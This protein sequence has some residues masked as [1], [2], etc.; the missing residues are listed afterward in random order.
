MDLKT[1]V[2][3]K[4]VQSGLKK[5]PMVFSQSLD[6][7]PSQLMHTSS[8]AGPTMTSTSTSTAGGLLRPSPSFLLSKQPS[9]TNPL[10]SNASIMSNHST[11][12][13]RSSATMGVGTGT[14]NHH[15]Q[16]ARLLR[17]DSAGSNDSLSMNLNDYVQHSLPIPSGSNYDDSS[18]HYNEGELLAEWDRDNSNGYHNTGL[19]SQVAENM[20]QGSLVL[21]DDDMESFS[22]KSALS[23]KTQTLHQA[24]GAM[25]NNPLLLPSSGKMG[26]KGNILSTSSG[27]GAGNNNNNVSFNNYS[28]GPE[29]STITDGTSVST[30]V[31]H[32]HHH[33]HNHRYAAN[34]G[35]ASS[36]HLQGI[37]PTPISHHQQQHHH[38]SSAGSIA[39]MTTTS[40]GGGGSSMSVT[41]TPQSRWKASNEPLS[42][43][44]SKKTLRPLLS[45][46]SSTLLP[47]I[48][49]TSEVTLKKIQKELLS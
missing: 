39:T 12:S 38:P 42:L 22:I 14:G 2:V 29:A 13:L 17:S 9:T 45:S 21:M 31:S 33:Q 48:T 19:V 49:N 36:H 3:N 44:A 1:V 37:L 6:Y 41:T 26:K 35:T 46:G 10:S 8:A 7:L 23:A 24:T 27:G 34:P 15:H 47:S 18:H 28:L 20:G 30:I 16:Y 32:Q 40:G 4:L 43:S 5:Y 25:N 11:S